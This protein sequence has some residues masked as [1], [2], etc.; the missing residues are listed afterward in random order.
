VPAKSIGER[1]SVKVIAVN[2]FPAVDGKSVR[3][4]IEQYAPVEMVHCSGMG[5]KKILLAM[6]LF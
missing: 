6:F 1:H 5:E 3:V 2:K 4:C